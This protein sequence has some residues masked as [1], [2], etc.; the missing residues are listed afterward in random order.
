[1]HEKRENLSDQGFGRDPYLLESEVEDQR[2]LKKKE[3]ETS[4]GKG[5][6]LR[7]RASSDKLKQKS[8]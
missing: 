8:L 2:Q 4:G 1:M 5:G 6:G 3:K 7:R